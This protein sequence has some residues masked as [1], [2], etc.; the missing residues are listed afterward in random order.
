[1][2]VWVVSASESAERD[3]AAI[4]KGTRSRVLMERAGTAAAK[5]IERRYV[6][7]LREGAAVFTGPGNNGGDGWVVAANLARFGVEVSVIEVAAPQAKSPDAVA[8]REAAVKTVRLAGSVQKGA[9]V[10]VDGLLGTGFEGEPRGKIADAIASIREL[11]LRG[12]AVA[13]LDVPSGLNATTG[14]HSSCVVADVTLSFGGIK[15]GTLLA[16]DCCGEIVAIDIGLDE[17]GRQGSQ[18]QPQLNLP[19]IVDAEFVRSR[20]PPIKFDAHKGTRKHLAI[21]GGRKG[22]HGAIVLRAQA[23]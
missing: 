12:A 19:A 13:A 21:L 9:P 2:P 14:E 5:E 17:A 7:R 16:R 1:M 20:I 23:A 15:R 22:M 10:V 3:R 11:H 6:E 18:A 8:Q 4:E